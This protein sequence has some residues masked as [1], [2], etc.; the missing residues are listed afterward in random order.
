MA[1]VTITGRNA[2]G[3]GC[4]RMP[5]RLTLFESIANQ[6]QQRHGVFLDQWSAGPGRR[7]G[8]ALL[9]AHQRRTLSDPTHEEEGGDTQLGIGQ[10]RQL[11]QGRG[12]R[13]SELVGG[14]G[15]CRWGGAAEC[16]PPSDCDQGGEGGKE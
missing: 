1:V 14:V 4:D 10:V 6:G 12:A 16:Q 2:F 8:A 3:P 7:R 15:K 13:Q 5:R 9:R 11:S